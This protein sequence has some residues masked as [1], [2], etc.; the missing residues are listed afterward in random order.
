MKFKISSEELK[1]IV[2]I[3]SRVCGVNLTLPVLN[4]ILL[5]LENGNLQ[6]FSTNLE[7]GILITIPVNSKEKGKISIPGKIFSEFVNSLPKQDVEINTDNFIINLKCGDYNAKILGQDPKD[8]PVLPEIKEKT[9]TN[10][11][12]KDLI[13]GFSKVS[14]I[15]SPLDTRTEISGI[16]VNFKKDKLIICGTDSIRLAEKTINLSGKIKDFSVII[17][18]K[19]TIEIGYIFSEYEGDVGIIVDK[20]QISFNFNPKN[21]KDPQINIVSRLI[22]GSFP[23]Y[24]EIIPKKIK[25]ESIF[26]KDEIYNKIK[27]AGLFSSKI[28]DIKLKFHPKSSKLSILAS[29]SNIGESQSQLKGK[30]KGEEMEINL[31]WKYFIDGLSIMNSSEVLV[32]VN[33]ATSPIIIRPVGDNTY[34]YILMPKTV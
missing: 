23:E 7:I 28:Q 9:I 14:N 21:K 12:S 30:I 29:S 19:T 6:F 15:V 24:K 18:Q 34:F 2:S 33:D 13:S 31:N 8:F 22:E 3:S 10:I 5:T 11:K 26:K 4:N 16:L 32:G 25:T 20:S 1:K 27:I 17:P